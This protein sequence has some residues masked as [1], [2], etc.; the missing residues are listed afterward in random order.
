MGI[1]QIKVIVLPINICGY[2]TREQ[3]SISV[4]LMVSSVKKRN[5]EQTKVIL[6]SGMEKNLMADAAYCHDASLERILGRST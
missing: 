5:Y 4:L 3:A 2:N 1:L 6:A